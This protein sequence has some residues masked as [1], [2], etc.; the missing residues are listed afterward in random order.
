MT[1]GFPLNSAHLCKFI[2]LNLVRCVWSN[3][4]DT[5]DGQKSWV[6]SVVVRVQKLIIMNNKK[7]TT[8]MLLVD[9]ANSDI[10]MVVAG[11]LRPHLPVGA[12]MSSKKFTKCFVFIFLMVKERARAHNSS[13]FRTNSLSQLYANS[14]QMRARHFMSFLH[15]NIVQ[16]FFMIAICLASK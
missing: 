5:L 13:I 14:S 1:N 10:L 9:G 2:N 11:S 12:C 7:K 6:N 3:M 4:I 8:T 16:M 15:A